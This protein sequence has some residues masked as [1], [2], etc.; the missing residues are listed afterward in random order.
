V[1]THNRL[2]PFVELEADDA[3]EL[4]AST[5]RAWDAYDEALAQVAGGPTDESSGST[6]QP[7]SDAAAALKSAP[8]AGAALRFVFPPG[9]GQTRR[10]WWSARFPTA[11][12]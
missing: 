2:W 8:I 5:A 1:L 12:E 6:E 10:H 4:D 9:D 11:H 3:W 7:T